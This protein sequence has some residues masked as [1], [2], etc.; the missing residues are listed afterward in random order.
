MKDTSLTALLKTAMDRHK[1]GDLDQ[2]ERLY[3]QILAIDPDNAEALNMLG[4]LASQ[5]DKDD[6]AIKLLQRAMTV[7]YRAPAYPFNLGN[8]Y[9]KIGYEDDAEECFKL[10][11][12]MDPGFFEANLVLG[13]IHLRK[14]DFYKACTYFE[15]AVQ[16]RSDQANLHIKLGLLY[17]KVS[18]IEKA[19]EHLE[20]AV[21][22]KSDDH[23]TLF[24]LGLIQTEAGRY[25]EAIAT[26]RRH[27]VLRP[28]NPDSHHNAGYLLSLVGRGE[29]AIE[30]YRKALSLNPSKAVTHHNLGNA[31]E[32]L[33]RHDNAFQCYKTAFE[34]DNEMNLAGNSLFF[35][36][37][38]MC[39][40][41]KSEHIRAVLHKRTERDIADK[42]KTAANPFIS[43][44]MYDSP[45]TH[46]AVA[47]SWSDSDR[48]MH[49]AAMSRFSHPDRPL[50]KNILKIGYLSGDFRNHPVSHQS[51]NM[52]GS[53][54]GKRFKICA[55]SYGP[56]EKDDFYNKVKTSC[57]A[58]IDIRGLSDYDAAR[59]IH[60]DG[61]DILVDLTGRSG[62][63]RF[64]ILAFKPSPIQVS[65]LGFLGTSGSRYMDYIITDRVVTPAQQA[66]FYSENFVYLPNCYQVNNYEHPRTECVFDRSDF[67]LPQ[68][69]TVFCSF[70]NTYKIE[71]N[72]FRAW[73]TILKRV[74]G[75]VLWLYR[76]NEAA[77][78]NLCFEAEKNGVERNRLIFSKSMPL[79]KH[80]GRLKLADI[81]LDT[82]VYNGGATTSNALAAGIP[83]VTLP[84]NSF[85]SRM[86]ASAL[87][88]CG[89]N[90]LTA[91]SL[92]EYIDIA[93]RLAQN[94]EKLNTVKKRLSDWSSIGDLFDTGQFVRNL[95]KAYE[96]MWSIYLNGESP[97]LI[98]IR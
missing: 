6:L 5:L 97:R 25:D 17:K 3:S 89:M 65:Y 23:E 77:M 32:S 60:V 2:A 90:E 8:V 52:F 1:I 76:E 15:H 64:G 69:E 43:L 46:Y 7:D 51:S 34:L 75:A 40:W 61:V 57:D 66:R 31:Y 83:V 71:P 29:E 33:G 47:R 56:A 9:M 88:A 82:I 12:S 19:L 59:K 72:V 68:R 49:K 45:A 36:Y 63:H 11:A 80:I 55:Y 14:G 73:M 91:G 74:P 24:Q 94:P 35:Y 78:K 50:D 18:D 84:G 53:H 95:E 93:V 87:N 22:L 27:N 26:Y 62:D 44:L 13:D 48:K 96:T 28:D 39:D 20:K 41:E 86:S 79:E 70:N 10:A 30:A 81:A 98:E 16:I 67:N 92:A 42:R 58:F 4:L 85:T 21:S 54:D 37:R 38:K